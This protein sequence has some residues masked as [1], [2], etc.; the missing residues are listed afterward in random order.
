MPFLSMLSQ[1]PSLT[2]QRGSSR[3]CAAPL[4][5]FTPEDLL[6]PSALSVW[7]DSLDE[8]WADAKLQPALSELQLQSSGAGG[9]DHGWPWGAEL[10]PLALLPGAGVALRQQ[11]P[12]KVTFQGPLPP[13]VPVCLPHLKHWLGIAPGWLYFSHLLMILSFLQS[14]NNFCSQIGDD[15]PLSYCHFSPNS[16]LL[17]TACW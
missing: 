5:L 9:T 1:I 15:R 14:L 6:L 17:A 4:I 11:L 8:L 13:P 16:K 2:K 12:L 3:A 10:C 7:L